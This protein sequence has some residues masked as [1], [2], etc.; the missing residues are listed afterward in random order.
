MAAKWLKHVMCVVRGLMGYLLA[1][2]DV[3]FAEDCFVVSTVKMVSAR[4]VEKN[5][6]RNRASLLEEQKSHYV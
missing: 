2:T 1:L 3:A 6:G 4:I 5:W